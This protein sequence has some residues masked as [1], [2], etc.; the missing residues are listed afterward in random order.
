MIFLIKTMISV[1]LCVVITTLKRL[2]FSI[3]ATPYVLMSL[4]CMTSSSFTLILFI[5]WFRHKYRKFIC[6]TVWILLLCFNYSMSFILLV[7]WFRRYDSS[8]EIWY[9]SNTFHK[10]NF[11]KLTPSYLGNVSF[12]T[13]A[14]TV[15]SPQPN[16]LCII[17]LC[18]CLSRL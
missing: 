8:Y 6:M 17:I 1:F 5:G 11:C 3:T 4:P 13:I 16:L 14:M 2:M 18:V 9:I 7:F 15:N 10:K 12:V